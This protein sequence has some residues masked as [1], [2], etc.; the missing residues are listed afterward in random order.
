MKWILSILILGVSSLSLS[1]QV[2]E[3]EELFQTLKT[4]D[5]LLFQCGL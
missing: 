4:K 2:A 5:S 3:E 1:A